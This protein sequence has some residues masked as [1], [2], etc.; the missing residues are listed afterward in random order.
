M[1][2]GEAQKL[3]KIKSKIFKN[4]WVQKPDGKKN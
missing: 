4:K 3:M 2:K 1:E